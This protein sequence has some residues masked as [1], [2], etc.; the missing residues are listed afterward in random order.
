MRPRFRVI[1]SADSCGENSQ[2]I[3]NGTYVVFGK[4][5]LLSFSYLSE[6]LSETLQVLIAT[7]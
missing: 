7:F 2:W 1:F 5:S 4:M 6:T 3:G